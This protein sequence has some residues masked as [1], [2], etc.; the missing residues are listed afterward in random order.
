MCNPLDGSV[1]GHASPSKFFS[2]FFFWI[3]PIY[4]LPNASFCPDKH[5]VADRFFAKRSLPSFSRSAWCW[6]LLGALSVG[7]CT[8]WWLCSGRVLVCI[9]SVE[10]ELFGPA[11]A[12]GLAELLGSMGAAEFEQ[13]YAGWLI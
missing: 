12:L 9:A 10:A 5:L 3:F 4:I 6:S 1:A 11:T 13:G 8:P 2:C 7:G